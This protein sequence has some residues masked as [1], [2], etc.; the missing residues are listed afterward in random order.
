MEGERLVI[1]ISQPEDNSVDANE[2][3]E[4][5]LH[6]IRNGITTPQEEE[7]EQ[8]HDENARQKN[9]QKRSNIM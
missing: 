3:G 8:R 5:L 9:I 2:V 6:L 4:G 7:D 1:R